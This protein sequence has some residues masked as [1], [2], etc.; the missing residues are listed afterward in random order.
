MR[1][2]LRLL[3]LI[4]LSHFAFGQRGYS[5]QFA[6][7]LYDNG[8]PVD[9]KTFCKEYKYVNVYGDILDISDKNSNK[10]D[11]GYNSKDSIFYVDISSMVYTFSF[12]LHHNNQVMTFFFPFEKR[13]PNYYYVDALEFR[14]GNYYFDFRN[15]ILPKADSIAYGQFYKVNK[16]NY[17]EL[18]KAFNE[19]NY[20]GRELIY[21]T[22]EIKE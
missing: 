8:K 17:E 18:E 2:L 14:K 22:S 20:L 13:T 19:S 12:A 21:Q 9:F 1:K 10:T 4:S 6:F 16:V 11:I 7:K 5:Y 3:F 15:E